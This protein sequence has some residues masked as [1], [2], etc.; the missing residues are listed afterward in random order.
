MGHHIF[1]VNTEVLNQ[2]FN[3]Y[4]DL[5]TIQCEFPKWP[6]TQGSY[7]YNLICYS[8]DILQDHIT[9]A[10]RIDTQLGDYYGYGKLPANGREGVLVDFIWH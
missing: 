9:G 1:T 2:N 5:V 7:I 8:N 10:G 6:L 4:D 3:V